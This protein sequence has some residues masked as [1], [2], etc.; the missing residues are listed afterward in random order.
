MAGKLCAPGVHWANAPTAFT[1][2]QMTTGAS[3]P[4]DTI[5][6]GEQSR[7]F[8]C[9]VVPSGGK[10]VVSAT[11]NVP[12]FDKDNL[13]LPIPTQIRL[14]TTIAQDESGAS[15]SLTVSDN[16]TAGISYQSTVCTFSVKS[17][18]SSNSKLA[19]GVGKAW[20]SVTCPN[21]ADDKSPS[22]S[23]TVDIG[24]FILENCDEQ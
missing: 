1:S 24:Y 16:D 11:I 2:A 22:S 18:P 5:I 23:C 7:Q 3:R 9:S 13:P 8:A 17:D 10:F 6:D 20:G 21:L 14:A 15:G 12:A 19:I 4:K